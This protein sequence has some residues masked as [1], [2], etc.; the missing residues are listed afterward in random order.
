MLDNYLSDLTA[1]LALM[2]KRLSSS[3]QECAQVL[4]S[5]ISELERDI[6]R[7]SMKIRAAN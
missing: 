5:A 4:K 7:Y 6:A 2:K 1:D 3:G